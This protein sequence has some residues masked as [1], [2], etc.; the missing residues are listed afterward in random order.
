MIRGGMPENE[1][2]IR[3][4]ARVLDLVLSLVVVGFVRIVAGKETAI[5]TYES[6]RS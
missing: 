3:T 2:R 1:T 6:L 4:A 5:R